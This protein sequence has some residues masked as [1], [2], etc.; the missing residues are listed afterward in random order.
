MA[1]LVYSSAA[2]GGRK[3]RQ[4]L[5]LVPLR[6]E[7]VRRQPAHKA[8]LQRRPLTVDHREPSG[9]ARA[10]LVHPTLAKGSLIAETKAQRRLPGG[11]LKALHFHS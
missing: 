8:G 7:V 3:G 9:I 6:I 5:V 4:A 11:W 2:Q 1:A 10:P